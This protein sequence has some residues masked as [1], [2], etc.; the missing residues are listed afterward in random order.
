M[1]IPSFFED[2]P[3]IETDVYG[4]TGTVAD[5]PSFMDD[6]AGWADRTLQRVRSRR[7]VPTKPPSL[8]DQAMGVAKEIG[9]KALEGFSTVVGAQKR[10]VD[11][12]ARASARVAGLTPSPEA[13]SEQL[14]RESVYPAKPEEGGLVDTGWLRNIAPGTQL[15]PKKGTAR[16]VLGD[17]AEF[18]MGMGL[19]LITYEMSLLH[20]PTAAQKVAKIG[21]KVASRVTGIPGLA[22]IP[23]SSA[24]KVP[25]GEWARTTMEEAPKAFERSAARKAVEKALHLGFSGQMG[26]G[27]AQ[28]FGES[29]RLAEEGDT[30][31]A[32]RAGV[33]GALSGAMVAAPAALKGAR[34]AREIATRKALREGRKEILGGTFAPD[35]P[36][37]IDSLPPELQDSATSVAGDIARRTIQEPGF[38]MEGLQLPPDLEPHREIIA[39][40]AQYE[41]ASLREGSGFLKKLQATF[42]DQGPIDVMREEDPKTPGRYYLVQRAK[43]DSGQ[44]RVVGGAQVDGDALT[45]VA[46][47][48]AF[49]SPESIRPIFETLDTLGV[50]RGQFLSPQGMRARRKQAEKRGLGPPVVEPVQEGEVVPD[51]VAQPAY[52]TEPVP[53]PPRRE[54][55]LGF[56]SQLR[57]VVDDPRTQGTQRGGDW[58]RFLGDPKRQVK[59][60]ELKWT[61]L[62]DWLKGKSGERVTRKEIQDYLDQNEVVVEEVRRGSKEVIKTPGDFAR[63]M[64]GQPMSRLSEQ[65]RMDVLTRH[66]EWVD[67]TRTEP[68]KFSQWQVPGGQ[69]YRELLLKLPKTPQKPAPMDVRPDTE[70]VEKWKKETEDLQLQASKIHQEAMSVENNPPGELRNMK[71]REVNYRRAEILSKMDGIR[72]KMV[73]ETLSRMPTLH[74]PPSVPETPFEAGHF[75]EPNVLAHVRM[76][77]R[78]DA[79]GKRVLFVEEIQSD[80]GQKGRKEGFAEGSVSALEQELEKVRR[81]RQ[82]VPWRTDTERTRADLDTRMVNLSSQL[83]KARGLP[84]APFVASTPQWT[85]L[86][87]KR[88]LKYA[89]DNGYDRVAWTPGEVQAERYDLSRQIDSIN[90]ER[91]SLPSVG[92]VADVRVYRNG[93]QVYAEGGV[94]PK[95]MEELIGKDMTKKVFDVPDEK[96]STFSGLD[97]K[98]GGEGMKSF[99]D[100]MVPQSFSRVAKK[101]GGRV[102][103]A[104]VESEGAPITVHSLDISPQMRGEISS[105]GFPLF[106]TGEKPPSEPALL[107]KTPEFRNLLLKL[108]PDNTHI[109]ESPNGWYHVTLPDRRTID[110]R[111]GVEHIEIDLTKSP[112]LA[113][114]R[115]LGVMYPLSNAALI[116]MVQGA[117]PRT[118]YHE[119]WHALKYLGGLSRDQLKKLETLYPDE[120]SQADAFAD[121][122]KAQRPRHTVFTRIWDAL[123]RLADWVTGR[124]PTKEERGAQQVFGEALETGLEPKPSPLTVEMLRGVPGPYR[125]REAAEPAFTTGVEPEAAPTYPLSTE[126]QPATIPTRETPSGTEPRF[127]T[128]PA[129]TPGVP[130]SPTTLPIESRGFEDFTRMERAT[131]KPPRV[132]QR[133]ETLKGAIAEQHSLGLPAKDLILDRDTRRTWK[134]LDPEIRKT[135][136]EWDDDRILNKIQRGGFLEDFEVQAL[137]AVTRGRREAVETSRLEYRSSKGT[138]EEDS[139]WRNYVESLAK[140]IPLERANVNDGTR[141]ARALSARA[142]LMQAAQT[143]DSAFLRQVLREFPGISDADATTLHRMFLDGDPQLA[144]AIRAQFTGFSKKFFTLWR[145]NLLSIPSEFAN[146]TG[147][148]MVQGMEILD[149]SL[150]SGVDWVLARTRGRG[151]RERY[152]AEVGAEL[153]GMANAAPTALYNFAQE[154]L[155]G[156]YKRAITGEARKI[157]PGTALEHQVSPFRNKLLGVPGLGRVVRL[158][159]TPLDALGIADDAAQ[160][161]IYPGELAGRSMR[162]AI[163]RLGKPKGSEVE[164]EAQRIL[165]DVMEN[166]EKYPDLIKS[167]R[168]ASARRVFREKPWEPVRWFQ[169]L[170]DQYPILTIVAPFI[171]TPANIARYAIRHSPVGFATPEIWKALSKYKEGKL[172]QGDFAD[173]IAPRISGT[174]VAGLATIMA[175]S[176]LITGAGP[177]D[178]GERKALLATGWQPYSVTITINGHKVWVPYSR[179]DPLSQTFG[180]VADIVELSDAKDFNDSFSRL[181]GS[182]ASNLLNRTYLRGLSDLANAYSDPKQY[183]ANYIASNANALTPAYLDKLAQAIDPVY[184]ETRPEDRSVKGLAQRIVNT[185]RSQTPWPIPYSSATLPA[186][187]TPTGEPAERPGGRGIAGGVARFFLPTLPSTERPGTELEALMA[188]VGEVPGE[189]RQY[190]TSQGKKVTLRPQEFQVLQRADQDAAKELRKLMQRSSFNRLPDTEDQAAPGQESKESVIGKVYRKHRSSARQLIW[191]SRSFRTHARE[192]LQQQTEEARAQVQS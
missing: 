94:E 149:R 191:R 152:F 170:Q 73:Q 127:A 70:A 51:L 3:Q 35:E 27:A 8:T 176:G 57:T 45:Y 48:R 171:R 114:R 109:K 117:D 157:R 119:H 64:F 76:N 183:L 175:R 88:I 139:A 172:S 72:Q 178:R 147:N 180:S 158:L 85:D 145:A 68:T 102:G 134:S 83:S 135:I 90:V 132:E 116:E 95:H 110:L 33:R 78:V 138:P 124:G 38:K 123:T 30:E 154:R 185:L 16:A 75:D 1:A 67:S 22:E 79:D 143:T 62:D 151:R 190:I 50:K 54:V 189:P 84:S 156:I 112:Q 71:L 46:G 55:G 98:V 74:R 155:Y 32:I 59:A 129:T 87:V 28:E 41:S 105:K 162:L 106:K 19:D 113:G 61:G 192:Q 2:D 10:K 153:G 89:A 86:A 91:Y 15:L 177:S 100:E 97:L 188:K 69:N 23:A 47:G 118:L 66:S 169:H 24:G 6:P 26:I 56:Y 34:K 52:T 60:D 174:L 181:T 159:T 25:I 18:A 165:S 161:I 9:G 141:V 36:L 13:T 17:I 37:P 5:E 146:T 168:D 12:L 58:L 160:S 65:D 80:W 7:K 107:P 187:L 148:V 130:P 40:Q 164:A 121:W 31:G 49:D 150:A 96:S 11:E 42:G 44:V 115:A 140:Y 167:A 111:P 81:E 92:P 53:T 142:R 184:R 21:S 29:A 173:I 82:A 128:A 163:Q 101:W 104:Q 186:K 103:Q 77:D 93:E 63:E 99:Y 122:V 136:I 131:G 14:I 120:E 133:V 43:D 39:R 137:D 126:A 20:A 108:Y 179:F 182:I 166:P 125:G 144:N 4:E